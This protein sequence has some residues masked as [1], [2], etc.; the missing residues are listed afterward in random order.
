MELQIGKWGNSLAVRLPAQVVRTLR[1]HEGARIELQIEEGGRA[2]L[3]TA[4]VFDKAAYLEQVRALTVRMPQPDVQ[5]DEES[6][7]R[8]M[9]DTDRY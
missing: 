2:V 3:R 5:A 1:L 6:F 8:W 9:R 7:V 4:P